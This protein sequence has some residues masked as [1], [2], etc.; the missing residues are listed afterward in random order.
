MTRTSAP[1]SLSPQ[2]ATAPADASGLASPARVAGQGTVRRRKGRH[3]GDG[4]VAAIML[5]PALLIIGAFV[6]YPIIGTGYLSLTSW[7]GYTETK[8]FIGFDNYVALVRDGD[9]RNSLMVTVVYG[10]GVCILGVVTGLGLASL[11]N[12][13]FRGRGAY[14]TIFFLPVVT[15]SIA[16]ATVWRYV[17]GGTGVVDRALTF[18]H[19][20][21]PNWLGDPHLALISLTLLTVWKCLG[22]NVILYL[23]ALQTLPEAIYEASSLDGAGRW[24]QMRHFT[25]PLLAPMTFFVVVEGLITSFQSF[26]LVYALTGGGPLGGTETLG[27]LTYRE[28]FRLSHFGYGASIAYAAF[29]LVL[30]VTLV[31]WRLGG[32]DKWAL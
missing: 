13:G 16:A 5:A 30:G 17:F 2:V 32:R 28:A 6:I 25:V 21:A 7:D 29:A 10:A 24:Q 1:A 4:K 26:D 31:Q 22:L 11:L 12:G 27:F 19:L 20:P 3:K 15:S 8:Q 23:A 14:R 9:F 18:L